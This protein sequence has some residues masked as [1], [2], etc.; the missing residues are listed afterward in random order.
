MENFKMNISFKWKA[1]SLF[2]LFAP[3]SIFAQDE[4]NTTVTSTSGEL[5]TDDYND[6]WKTPRITDEMTIDDE[7]NKSWRMGDY[8]FSSQPKHSWEVGIHG[9]HFFIDGD[10]DRAI[11][12]GYGLGVHLRKAINYSFSIRGSLFYGQATG[13][14]NQF[15]GHRN[16]T[17][18]NTGVTQIG[19]GLV[20]NTFDAYDPNIGG[21]GEWIPSHR[22]DYIAADLAI[23]FNI[24]NLLFHKERNK[25]NWYAGIGIGLDHHTV[26]LDLFDESGNTYNNVRETIN[27]TQERFNTRAGR[28]EIEA[29]INELY[30]GVYETEGFQK[31]GIFRFGDDFNVHVIFV[32]SMGISRKITKRLNIGIEHQIYLSDND[33]LD[34]IKF[35][36]SVDQ[37][38]N[39]DIPH[40]TNLRVGFN[41]GNFDK[42]TEPLYWLNPMDIAFSDI[43]NLKN[44]PQLDLTDEDQDGVIDMLDQELDTPEGCPVDTRGVLL[45]S[46]GDGIVDCEDREP[47]SRPGCPIDEFGVANCEEECCASEDEINKLID[48]RAEQFKSEISAGLN[49][50]N[51]INGATGATGAAGATRY[52]EKQVTNPDGTTRTV[53]EAVPGTSRTIVNSGCGDWFLPM[54]HYD[55]NKSSI[56]PEYFSHLHNVAQVLNKCPNVCVTA[57]GYTDSRNS[58]DYNRVLSYKRA[59]SAVDYLVDNYNIDRSRLKLMYGGEENPMVN[60]PSSEAHHFMNRRVEFR[61]CEASDFDMPAPDGTSTLSA[62]GSSGAQSDYY[63]GNKSSGY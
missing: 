38:N 34:G 8:K 16:N 7:Q 54:I 40:Y 29:A 26:N 46:D 42:V 63:K 41:I 6:T 1:L 55:L 9:G 49:G 57:Q 32:P 33:Y 21:P 20:E 14:E 28:N 12:G 35:R 27:W 3:L 36:T 45:D 22:T 10:V 37:T 39:V 24:G 31:A 61:T 17:F 2:L 47:Y 53:R 52:I 11:P 25:W 13:I 48:A 19:G 23:I 58:N 5:D 62:G 18:S 30:D 4:N 44:Q 15:W 59:Q 60:S 43:N 50:V 56:K 51:G